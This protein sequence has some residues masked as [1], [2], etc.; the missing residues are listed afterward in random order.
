MYCFL[1]INI[2]SLNLYVDK[3]LSYCWVYTKDLNNPANNLYTS[4]PRPPNKLTGQSDQQRALKLAQTAINGQ[5]INPGK[6]REVT[7]P[8]SR[9]DNGWIMSGH[10]PD[11]IK[12]L[13]NVWY[14]KA[15]DFGSRGQIAALF[16][17]VKL[18]G[19]RNGHGA[20]PRFGGVCENCQMI[21]DRYVVIVKGD[22][23]IL[24]VLWRIDWMRLHCDACHSP[25]IYLAL[26][27]S[28]LYSATVSSSTTDMVLII[29][30]SK[31][32]LN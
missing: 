31:S 12:P 20:V 22:N 18:T 27:N 9:Q 17:A 1:G 30:L 23:S 32:R 15:P 5:G 3:C 4:P 24:F 11:A 16:V 8:R 2:S 6:P 19:V 25:Q 29:K 13:K 26:M 10:L 7:W 14:I 28:L 21:D